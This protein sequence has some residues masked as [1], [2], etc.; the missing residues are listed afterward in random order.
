MSAG[1]CLSSLASGS[2]ASRLV[3]IRIKG[4]IYQ[5]STLLSHEASKHLVIA[6]CSCNRKWIS[7]DHQ[8][9]QARQLG[10]AVE[11][12]LFQFY[13]IETQVQLL[14]EAKCASI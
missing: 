1:Y 4:F 14:E 3:W 12:A 10:W 2:S 6:L 5:L 13:T 8:H 9:F 11:Q 7:C